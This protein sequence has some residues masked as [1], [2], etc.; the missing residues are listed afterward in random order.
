L[1]S[2]TSK[3]SGQE[4]TLVLGLSSDEVRRVIGGTP[5]NVRM[6]NFGVKDVNSERYYML[7]VETPEVAQWRAA[8]LV[9]PEYV[10]I[11]CVIRRHLEQLLVEGNWRMLPRDTDGCEVLLVGGDSWT[12]V[13]VAMDAAGV[14]W[15]T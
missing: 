14:P 4:R 6:S 5:V 15:P 8:G 13:K 2:I 1:R 12:V 3:P 9:S 7:H 11:D 10:R